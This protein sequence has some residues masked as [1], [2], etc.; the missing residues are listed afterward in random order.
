MTDKTD[1]LLTERNS[2]HGDFALN[3][4]FSQKLKRLIREAPGYSA[5]HPVHREALDVIA[6]K[7]SRVLSG[8]PY[9]S[10]HWAD[11]A[12]Y[13][14]LAERV[15]PPFDINAQKAPD[16]GVPRAPEVI[17]N[18][19]E[20]YPPRHPHPLNSCYNCGGPLVARTN[21]TDDGMWCKKCGWKQ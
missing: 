14:R 16:A 19:G 13:A 4:D 6:L 8:R 17:D 9:E 10:D 3:A 15:A 2:T 11:I 5:L 7:I 18:Q 1:A 12:G 21:S 20:K